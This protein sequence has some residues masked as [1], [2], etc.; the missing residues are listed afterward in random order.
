MALNGA[1]E[2]VR[3]RG[4]NKAMSAGL[5]FGDVGRA[6]VPLGGLLN[7]VVGARVLGQRRPRPHAVTGNPR[8]ACPEKSRDSRSRVLAA[9]GQVHRQ[10]R[11]VCVFSIRAVHQVRSQLR[12]ERVERELEARFGTQLS[13]T[14]KMHPLGV[15]RSHGLR[16]RNFDLE[17]FT[18]LHNRS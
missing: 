9:F 13:P 15:S 6:Q 11:G 2:G 8:G 16:S 14:R 12:R 18:C 3:Y 4:C 10:E 7:D 5:P 17:P 1:V